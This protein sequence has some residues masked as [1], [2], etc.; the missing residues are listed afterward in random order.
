MRLPHRTAFTA[1]SLARRT[2][3]SCHS[4]LLRGPRALSRLCVQR[5]AAPVRPVLSVVSAW[6]YVDTDT[7]GVLWRSSCN[8][9]C[10]H[11]ADETA[12]KPNE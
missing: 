3:A 7:V 6:H 2:A 4:F 11:F 1:E 12:Q 9:Q 10:K 8:L 5:S